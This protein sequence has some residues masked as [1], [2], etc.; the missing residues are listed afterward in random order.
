MGDSQQDLACEEY[1]EL[2]ATIRQRG[3]LRPALVVATMGAWGALAV[4]TSAVFPLPIATLV[5]L[6]VL[7][8]GFEAIAGLHM[9]VERIGRYVQVRF[10]GDLSGSA[11][12]AASDPAWERTSMAWGARF[13]GTGTDPLFSAIF[14][15]AAIINAVPVALTGALPELAVLGLAH[16]AFAWRVWRVRAWSARQRQEDLARFREL[17]SVTRDRQSEEQRAGGAFPRVG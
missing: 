6:V 4:A 13:P 16:L 5:P 2:R 7:A 11:A 15:L 17:A 10:E 3:N 1:R 14:L 12:P 8:A 9:G